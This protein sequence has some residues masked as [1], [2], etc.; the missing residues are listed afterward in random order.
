MANMRPARVSLIVM[1]SLAVPG[2]TPAAPVE[3]ARYHADGQIVLGGEGG[4]DYLTADPVARRLYVTH[5]TRVLVVDLDRRIVVVELPGTRGVHGVA[6]AP[7][8]RR[9]F[10]SN[11]FDSTVTIFDLDSLKLLST[12]RIPGRNPDAILFEPATRRVLVFNGGSGTTTALDAA[13]GEV[14]GTLT[15]GGK[16]EFAVADGHGGVFV[17]LED[18][19]TVV[20]F[21]AAT[22]APRSRWPLAP[23]EE[24]TGLAIDRAHQRLFV[25]CHNQQMIVMD[26][27]S[28]RVVASV[29]IGAGVDGVAFDSTAALAFSSNGDGTL[30]VVKEES[31]ERFSVVANVAT[32][33]GARTLALDPVTHRVYLVTADFGPTPPATP[34]HPRPRPPMVPNTFQVLIYSP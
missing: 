34:E 1:L 2:S 5:G 9:G 20:A 14:L 16:P 24:P 3:G 7:G 26:S 18:S 8:L 30:T 19:S 31:P 32:R 22:L 4:W 6:L 27:G 29:A 25:G 12:V 17:N 28:G 11:G 21:D 23:G 33:R 15:L 13:T 10:T